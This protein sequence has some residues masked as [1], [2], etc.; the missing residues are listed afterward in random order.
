MQNK[1]DNIISN[2]R[3]FI[4]NKYGREKNQSQDSIIENEENRDQV[5]QVSGQ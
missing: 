5:L 3:S 1:G 2:Q 4:E